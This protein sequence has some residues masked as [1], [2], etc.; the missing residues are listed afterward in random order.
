MTNVA[1]YPTDTRAKGWRFELDHERIRQSD[2]WAL[3]APE[4]RPWLLMLWMTAWEQTPCGSLPNED[5]L[6]AARIGMPLDLFQAAKGRLL[7]GWWL[8]DDGRLYHDTLAERVLDMIERRDGEKIRKAEYRERQKQAKKAAEA[9][10]GRESGPNLSQGSPEMSHGTATGLPRDSTGRDATGTGTGTGTS[11]TKEQ[12]AAASSSRASACE[13]TV[14]P[15]PLGADQSPAE[16]AQAV[17]VWLRRNE[18]TRGKQP[19][20]TQGSDPRIAAWIKAGVTGLQLAEAYALALLDRQATGDPGPIT[21]GFLDVFVAKVLNPA[22]GES[23][24]KKPAP[25]EPLLWATTWTGVV[26]KGQALGIA[27]HDGEPFP[28]YKVRVHKAAGVTDA[29]RRRMLA[30]YGASI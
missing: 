10:A 7:R 9:A 8:A 20:G 21:P 1:P 4:I 30:D 11:N 24:V 12:T 22:V 28:A 2:T 3:A 14:A 29:D 16:L 23:R 27:Q 19:R 18:Q 13:A 25:T 17:A 26:Q 15:P 5:E 6:I